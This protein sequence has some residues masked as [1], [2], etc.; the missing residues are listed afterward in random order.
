MDIQLAKKP[1]Y[2]RHRYYLMSGAIFMKREI[3]SH[4]SKSV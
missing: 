1:W 4:P 2:I 3:K